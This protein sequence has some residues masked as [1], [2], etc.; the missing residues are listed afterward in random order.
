[1]EIYCF[2]FFFQLC[3][4]LIYDISNDYHQSIGRLC[5]VLQTLIGNSLGKLHLPTH[6]DEDLFKAIQ[7]QANDTDLMNEWYQ[8]NEQSNAYTLRKDYR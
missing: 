1:M 3:F 4:G 7:R 5:R 6:L 2:S 8:Y